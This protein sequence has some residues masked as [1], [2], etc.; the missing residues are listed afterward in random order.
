MKYGS[1][2][3]VE[4][5]PLM[6]IP[7]KLIRSYSLGIFNHV[8]WVELEQYYALNILSITVDESLSFYL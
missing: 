5:V 6:P 4:S 2:E 3:S 1:K 8:T 7:G